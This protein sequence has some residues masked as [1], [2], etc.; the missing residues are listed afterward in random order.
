MLFDPMRVSAAQHTIPVLWPDTEI[1]IDPW[2]DDAWAVGAA[3]LVL[4]EVFRSPVQK[5]VPNSS[6]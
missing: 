1:I 2:G 6:V 5:A 3:S 4:G